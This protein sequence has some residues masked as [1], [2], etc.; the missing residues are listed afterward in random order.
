MAI[1]AAA[2]FQARPIELGALV[3]RAPD[4]EPHPAQPAAR[5]RAIVLD[6]ALGSE[7][8]ARDLVARLATASARPAVVVVVDRARPEGL[9]AALDAGARALLHRWCQPEELVDAVRAALAGSDRIAA[10]LAGLLRAE[11]LADASGDHGRRL[12]SREQQVLRGLATG[13]TNAAI[14]ARLGISEHTVRNHVRAILAK[15]EATNRTDAV[16]TALRRGLVDLTV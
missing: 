10:P 15:L 5:P 16:T 14:G 6:A 2:G 3:D 9:L 1:L 12:S 8:Y 7:P 13:A 11:V 4:A